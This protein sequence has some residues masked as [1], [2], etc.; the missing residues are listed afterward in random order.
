MER[1]RNYHVGGSQ[2]SNARRKTPIAAEFE[3]C[4][5]VFQQLCSSLE[6]G[7]TAWGGS[8]SELAGLFGRLRSWGNESGASTR[9]LDHRLRKASRLQNQVLEFL[10]D[11]KVDLESGKLHDVLWYLI[12]TLGA[13]ICL[14]HTQAPTHRVIGVH[15]FEFIIE[16]PI[17][18]TFLIQSQVMLPNGLEHHK[19][20]TIGKF[21]SRF[22]HY[23]IPVSKSNLINPLCGKIDSLRLRYLRASMRHKI[24]ESGS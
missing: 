2:K 13:L 4:I 10:G 23:N 11:L 16:Q 9:S 8:D 5:Q 20:P 24:S 14:F 21:K 3:D 22:F 19:A 18:C 1:S 6:A 15:Y 17:C 12:T 7:S